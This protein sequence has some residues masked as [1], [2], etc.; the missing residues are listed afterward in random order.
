MKKIGKVRLEEIF[1]RK[2]SFIMELLC[3]ENGD[4]IKEF[5]EDNFLM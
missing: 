5:R 4:R 2:E 3:F 1:G